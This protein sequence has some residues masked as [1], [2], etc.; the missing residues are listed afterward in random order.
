MV[1]IVA[2]AVVSLFA[3]TIT[4]A[5]GYG[6][7]SIS[8]PIA[9]LLISNRVLNPALVVVE[10]SVNGYAAVLNRRAIRAILPRVTFII[11]GIVPGVLLGSWFLSGLPVKTVKT[12][13]YVTMLPLIL[14]QAA[15]L[16]FPLR[17]ERTLAVPFGLG[18][19]TLYS[20]TT[21]SGPPLA[22]FFNNQGLTKDEFRVALAVTRVVESLLTLITYTALGLLTQQSGELALWLAPGVLIGI[23]LGHAL[24][25]KISPETFRRVCMS[26]D[27]WLVAF[28]LSRIVPPLIGYPVFAL[29][30][31]LDAVLLHRFF[32][33]RAASAED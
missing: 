13:V 9:L 6:Y 11:I 16:R 18:I 33:K 2:L 27:A 19:G 21:I 32:A 4:G 28:G 29:T 1:V 26:F 8:V 3:A 5:L 23:P 15:G 25:K 10:S 12:V 7:S 14:A 30:I 17:R 20:L 31:V 24:I 22:M